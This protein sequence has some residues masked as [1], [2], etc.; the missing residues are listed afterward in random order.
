[1]KKVLLVLAIGCLF[2]C[3]SGNQEEA[4]TD[5]TAAT[6]AETTAPASSLI[7]ESEYG[8]MK[9]GIQAY[10]DGNQEVWMSGYAENAKVYHPG[11][12][13]SLVGKAGLEAF[14]K[15]RMDS[16][17]SASFVNATY[18]GID[19]QVDGSTLKGKWLMA[20]GVFNIKYKNG[21]TAVLPIHLV[22]HLDAAGKTDLAAWYYDQMDIVNAK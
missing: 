11:P 14:F 3:N 15:Q 10:C 6:P 21:K 13:D 17:A 9:N 7:P 19:N 16:V 12:G 5:A 2:A 20:W 1:M 4:K 8:P 18:A 22:H